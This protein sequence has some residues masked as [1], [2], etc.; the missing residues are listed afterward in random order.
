MPEELKPVNL[1]FTPPDLV[2][3]YDMPYETSV[4]NRTNYLD[5]F[6]NLLAQNGQNTTRDLPVVSTAGI[7]FSGRYPKFYPGRDNE[8]MYAQGQGSL[9][10]AYNGVAKMAGIAATSF[11]AGTAGLVY[12]IGKSIADQKFS[13]FYNNELTNSLNEFNKD[14]ENKYAHYRTERERNGN[15]WEPSNLLTGNFLWDNIVKN[16]GYSLGAAA[17]G[18]AWGA[19]LK[20]VGLTGKLIGT[21]AEMAAKADAAIADAAML[22]ATERLSTLTSNL[23]GLGNSAIS[24]VGKGLMKADRGIVATFGTVG[25]AGLEALNNSQEFRRNM[26]DEFTKTHGYA[27][28]EGDL[29]K[30]NEYAESVGNWSF[31]LNAALLTATNYIQLPKIYSS[32]FKNEKEILNNVIFK[33]GKY[34]S[35]LPEKGFGK[36]LYKS[37]NVA[38]LFFN[39]AEAFEEGAQ[40]AIQTGTQNYFSKKQRNKEASALDDGILHGV[41]E[42]LTSDEGLLNIFTGGFSGALQSSGFLGIKKN[43]QGMYMPTIGSTGKIGER[44]LTGYGGSE[45]EFRN[46]AINVLNNTLIKNKLKDAYSNIKASEIIQEQRERA[47]RIGDVLESKD[48]E[49][50]YAHNFITS[51]LKYDAKDAI[52]DEINMLRQEAMTD[53]G[54]LELKQQGYAAETDT[55]DSFLNR[56][57]NLEEHA[58]NT[59]KLYEATNIKYKG[60]IDP[61]TGERMYSDETIDKLVYAASKIN[62]YDK[63]VP[64]LSKDLINAGV[65]VDDVL[66]GIIKNNKPNKEATQEAL[67][68]INSLDVIS[69]VKNDLKS[70]LTDVIELSLRR[71]MFMEEYD[72]IK[73]SPKEFFTS[74]EELETPVTIKQ[75]E[76]TEDGKTKVVEKELEVGKEYSLQGF[77]SREGN[78]LQLAPKISI[79]SKTLGGE[80]EVKLPN[81]KVSYLSPSDFKNY[82]ITE[83]SNTSKEATDILNKA[84][85]TVLN[86]KE[87][88][89]I[90]V[91]EENRLEFINS[92]DNK[93]LIDAIQKEFDLKSKEFVEKQKAAS[94][95]K[96]RLIKYTQ[97]ITKEQEEIEKTSGDIPTGEGPSDS[98]VTDTWE[99]KKKNWD[100]LFTATTTDSIDW[101]KKQGRTL[102]PH[103]TYFNEFINNVKSFSNRKNIK[104]ILVT[105]NQEKSL[106]LEGLANLSFRTD[107]FNI[108][109]TKDLNVGFVGAVFIQIDK[110]GNRQFIDKDGNPIGEVGSPV[111][112]SKVVFSTMPISGPNSLIF[113]NNEPRYRNGQQEEA[114]QA[115]AWWQEK[116]K[117]LFAAPEGSYLMFDFGVSKGIPNINKESPETNFVAVSGLAK[118]REEA[119]KIIATQEGLIEISTKGAIAHEDGTSYKFAVG[120]PVLKF[121]DILEF[122]FNAKLNKNKATAIFEV[123]KKWS[124]E[125]NKQTKEG[126]TYSINKEYADFLKNVL[127]WRSTGAKSNNKIYL[128]P[129]TSTLHIGDK[130]YDFINIANER[131]NIINDLQ[132]VYFNV[133]NKTL[134]L[135]LSVPFTEF[136]LNN[137]GELEKRVWKNYQS[138]LLSS[139]NPDGSS[140]SIEDAPLYTNISK[141]S[142]EIPYTHKQKYAYLLGLSEGFQVVK[143]EKKAAQIVTETPSISTKERKFDYKN[144]KENSF[145]TKFGKIVFKADEEG[146]FEVME[147]NPEVVEVRS[148][149]VDLLKKGPLKDASFEQII[150]QANKEIDI[151]VVKEIKKDLASEAIET[152]TP[153][154]APQ[155]EVSVPNVQGR[156]AGQGTSIEL[157][158]KGESG[159]EFLLFIDRNNKDKV[160]LYSEKKDWG[161]GTFIYRPGEGEQA[162]Q[163]QVTKLYNKYVPESVRNLITD[164]QN[165]FTGSW[166]APETEDGKHHRDI[167]AK[168]KTEL[169]NLEGTKAVE[170]TP[171]ETTKPRDFRGR[172]KKGPEYR[173]VGKQP[174]RE[175]TEAEIQLFKKWAADKVPGIPYE[176]LDNIIEV[177][178]TKRA[179]GAFEDGVA[180]IFKRAEK[181]TEYHEIFEGIWKGFLSDAQKEAILAEFKS[182]PGTFLDRESGRQIPYSR[183]TDKEAKERIADDFADFRLGKIAKKSLS[184]KIGEFFKAIVDF[185][186]SF[187]TKPSLK[188]ELFKAIDTGE[189]KKMVFP[190]AKINEAAEYKPI[191]GLNER[192]TNDF[193]Q[194]I[195]SRIFEKAFINNKS[196]FYPQEFLTGEV[197]NQV[198]QDFIKEDLIGDDP[199][200]QI[201]NGMY[202]ELLDRTKDFLKTFKIEIDE[203]SKI[204][205]NSEDSNN[206]DYASDTFSVDFKKSSPYAIKLLI[207][208]LIKTKG[209]NQEAAAEMELPEADTDQ[210]SVY[211]YTLVPFNR[212]YSTLMNTLSNERDV[213]VFVN[214]LANLARKNSDYVR[215]FKRLG[216][217]LKTGKIDFNSYDETDWRLFINFFQVFTKQ[218]PDILIEYVDGNQVYSGDANQASIKKQISSGWLENMKDLANNPDSLIKLENRVYRVNKDSEDY[219]KQTPNNPQDSIKFLN[220]LGI[221]FP[222][223]TFTR[224]RGSELTRF[225]DA[226]S[227]IKISLDRG[228]ELFSLKKKTLG[229]S[230]HLDTLSELYVLVNSP[231][232]DSTFFNAEGKRQQSNTDANAP[233]Y[234]EYM[235]NSVDTLEEL[236]QKYPQILDVFS[237]NSQVLKPGGLFFNTKGERIKDLKVKVISGLQNKSDNKGKSMSDLSEGNR[238]TIEINKNLNGDYYV[239]IPADG[240]TEWMMNL[241]NTVGF[242]ELDSK[243]TYDIFHG[244][245]VDDILLAQDASNRDKLKYVGS[246][247]KDLRIFKDILSDDLLKEVNNLV[248]SKASQ[249]EIQ[250]FIDTNSKKINEQIDDF[251]NGVN[252][253]T[254]QRLLDSSEAAFVTKEDKKGNKKEWFTYKGLDQKF[255]DKFGLN[256]NQ[257]TEK[258]FNDIIK[259]VNINYIINNIEYHKI[260]FGDPYQFKITDKKGKVIL[261]E[262]KRIKSFLSPRRIT[263]NHPAYNSFLNREY[264]TVAGVNLT[265]KDYGYHQHKDFAK[266]F[267]AEDVNSTNTYLASIF[268]SYAKSNEADASSLMMDSTYKE[269][270]LK[271]GQW[272]NEAE[273]WHQWQMAYTRQNIP[274]YKYTSKELEKHD[275]ELVSKPAP[276]HFIDVLKPIVSGNKFGKTTMDGVLDKFSQFPM[277]YSTVK[278]TNLEKLY[279]KMFNEGYD[280]V[281]MESGRKE[282]IEELYPLYK[283]NG[284]L[285]DAPFNNTINVPWDVYGIQVENS[286][287]KEKLQTRGSQ[288]TK[289]ATLDLFSGGEPIG[290]TEERK[291]IIKNEVNKNRDLLDSMHIHGY[292]MLLKKLGIQD[293]GDG[294]SIENKSDVANTLRQEIFK[295]EISQ[296]G[297]DSLTL[298]PLTG[299]FMIP[300]EASTNY[301]QIKDI[302]YS[303][304][305]KSIVSTKMNGFPAVQVA[306]TGWES[307]SKGRSIALKTEEG[308]KKISKEEYEKLSEEEKTKVVLTDDTLKFYTKEEPWCEVLLPNWMKK[309]LPKGMTDEQL[310]EYLNKKQNQHI[311]MGIG[312]RIPT[313]ALSSVEVFKVKG[314]LPEYMG[315]TVVV[316]SAITTKAGSDFDI[317]K[318]NMYLKNVYLDVNGNVQAVQLINNEADTKKFYG[319]LYDKKI[320]KEIN[321]IEK[322]DEFRNQLVNIFS[323]LETLEEFTYDAIKSKLTEDEMDFY[324]DH[325]EILQTI[326]N[327]AAEQELNPSD[328]I[329]EQIKE[330]T[331]TKEELKIKLLNTTL[332]ENYLD[333]MY[334]KALENAYYDSLQTLLTLPENFERLVKPNDDETLKEL[335]DELDRLRGEDESKIKNRILNRNY[336]TNLRHAFITAKR[337]VGIAAVNITGHSLYQKTE[338]Y[339]KNRD[340]SIIF[341]HNT[342]VKDGYKHI[343]LSAVLDKSGKYISDKLSMYANAFV[344]V[345][346]DPYILKIIFS[347]RVVSTFMFLERAGVSMENTAMFMNQPII[348]KFINYLDSTNKSISATT[349]KREIDYIKTLFPTTKEALNST[350]INTDNLKQNISK[351]SQDK[352]LTDRENAEQQLLLDEFVKYTKLA[353]AN[354][355]IT[356]AINYDTTSFGSADELNRKQVK[357]ELE[358]ASNLISSPNKILNSSFLGELSSLLDKSTIALGEILKFNQFDFRSIIKDAIRDYAANQY[359]SKDKFKR[360]SEKLSASFLDYIIQIKSDVINVKQLVTG[361]ESVANRIEAAKIAHP[362]VR[363]LQ[364]FERVSTDLPGGTQSVKLK[365]NLKDAYEENLYIGYMREMRDNPATYDLY[366]DLV[367][368]AIVQG[369][370]QS[371]ISFKNIVPIED[372]AAVVAPIMQNVIVDE[373]IKNFAINN[374]FQ[375][376]NYKDGDIVVKVNPTFWDVNGPGYSEINIDPY[377]GYPL[378]SSYWSPSFPEI[379]TLGITPVHRRIFELSPKAIGAGNNLI[380]VSRVVSLNGGSEMIDFITGKTITSFDF[381]E[382]KLKGDTSLYRTYGYQLVKKTDGSPLLTP[383]GYYVYKLANLY[384]DGQYASEYYPA[385]VRSQLNNNTEQIQT[386]IPDEDIRAYYNEIGEKSLPSQPMESTKPVITPVI[387]SS[388]K[389]N[390]YAGTGE[391]TDLSNFAVRP[392]TD[393]G[394]GDLGMNYKEA[395][396]KSIVFNTVEGFFQA[397]KIQYS[398]SSEYWDKSK[399]AWILTKRGIE[400][401][402]KFAKATGSEAK[403]LGRTIKELDTKEWDK[404]SLQEMEGGLLESFKQNPAA[405]EK[406]FATGNATLTHTQD[407]GKWG[408]EFP[409]LLMEVR[410]ELRPTQPVSGELEIDTKRKTIKLKDTVTYGFNAISSAMLEKMGYSSEEIG[411][412]LKSIC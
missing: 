316:P 140:R 17:G 111:D 307:A 150:E 241:G 120:R 92:L 227:G 297:I 27:P 191:A 375:R 63:R 38:G 275:K 157:E 23:K 154:V 193:V 70:K 106:G 268:P 54:F 230:G 270:K 129:N 279:I 102:S 277:Y 170:T 343:S 378:P 153:V 254:K 14:W 176:F 174:I 145:P 392:F 232:E 144:Q 322:Y 242:K 117:E 98:T 325:I 195:T 156:I 296:N 104:A 412:I 105:P 245:L 26:I 286:Y 294:Y 185:F 409:K 127:Y 10:K 363:I 233:S 64:Q 180:K 128:D 113:S 342:I 78:Q 53:N 20:A 35:S 204:S 109:D 390:I 188:D 345:A 366:Q 259:F 332:K 82:Q 122:L 267:T 319:D 209:R 354:F 198:K 207:G 11:V 79:I 306:V 186:K 310:L 335:A 99:S 2:G 89:T 148:K 31:G 22:P 326:I 246:K 312:F 19:A 278:G 337:W 214:K 411:K 238:T 222:M 160:E 315:R 408:T 161:D 61:N 352:K 190:T 339:V 5:I 94:A 62:D 3:K 261:D 43:A 221:A 244:Y 86:K 243:K 210:S 355:A 173:M 57:S 56:L 333:D 398:T 68:Q 369:T 168:L 34:V 97:Q 282:G 223:S 288:L 260:L 324:E 95:A 285:N 151:L 356:Q 274:G 368:L 164:W 187:V 383:K 42:A 255:L 108:I 123:L 291:E 334:K 203:D 121:A 248:E 87:F 7:D 231:A 365:V 318:L 202:N 374:M 50:D 252:K 226:V 175:M 75:V 74:F 386:E 405:L 182:K 404:Y 348:R 220:N 276:A 403:S 166:A 158:I 8:E 290:D 225:A 361:K 165:S 6:N 1:P 377:T 84:I 39:E 66:E 314:F 141:A 49:F 384:G 208:T 149:I 217:N 262:T 364:D 382:R 107:G 213:D 389:I 237:T 162:S 372:Y 178:N 91:P 119:E 41:K 77:I 305:D 143:K 200:T 15:W 69:D 18:F 311:L 80:Y 258:E 370:Y 247:G 391:N 16:L 401:I 373:D 284:D 397:S 289:L 273:A 155:P 30:I 118:T 219:P 112:L 183:A 215:L 132:S 329:S 36:L 406:L 292:R 194:D 357:T 300:L 224:L 33:E 256:K 88:K 376:N 402:E 272:T 9:E 163:E 45:G 328:F 72:N 323:K 212:V 159:K 28:T 388:R 58:N 184:Q 60:I 211:G 85:E 137:K 83:V 229:I 24:T 142:P 407:K 124:E 298:D 12:G 250:A 264:N 240:S 114:E 136:Y 371:A 338:V 400:L 257:L 37:K 293:L 387:D 46:T 21:G 133:N 101:A 280:Y 396:G 55:K 25:E 110:K 235:F 32:S 380:A 76:K 410:E 301:K 126:K 125:T 44:G 360:I 395:T 340:S 103:I 313:Q 216:G 100:R 172:T 327:Q 287:E 302:L 317:D 169:T 320:Q 303:I 130:T 394:I 93:K 379:E 281:I 96:E 350:T 51:R 331:G 59:A 4:K 197:L 367:K 344:D 139:Y 336:M 179:W 393:N 116:R 385:P 192:Q 308:Y 65:I 196:L 171:Q 265:D 71:K 115:A 295:R 135:G 146:Q 236:Q 201:T 234:L 40:Y 52:N 271:N 206:R 359:I 147:N 138:F 199:N 189:F 48:L 269:V 399:D 13:S 131:D 81:G 67:K 330:L 266:T 29:N 251:I 362:E 309:V 321:K 47:I 263:F 347:N 73:K 167:E 134:S 249:E 228:T 239:L 181:G 253:E 304:V 177:N 218:K 90:E 353:N 351:Y 381:K 346:K 341:D 358:E 299:D 349:S 283:S 152:L 205:I